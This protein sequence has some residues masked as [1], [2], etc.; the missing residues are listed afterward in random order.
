MGTTSLGTGLRLKSLGILFIC[1]L[2]AGIWLTYGVF[3]Q[4]FTDFDE[5][6]LDAPAIGL[7]MPERADVK[8]RGVIVGQVL[9][10]SATDEGATV[11]LGIYPSQL[12]TIPSNVTGAIVPKTLFGEKYVSLVVPHDEPATTSLQPGSTIPRTH[13]PVEVQKVLADLYPLLRTVQ[14]ADLNLTLNAISTALEGRGEALGGD[15]VTVDRYLKRINPQIPQLV[16]Y[17][18]LTTKVSNTYA[19]VLPSI[20]QI[21]DNTITTTGTL[22]DRHQQ[23]QALFTDVSSLSDIAR[24]FLRANGDNIIRLGQVSRPQAQMLARYAP[25]YPCLLGGLVNAGKREAQAF[26]GFTLHIV[27]ETLPN[28]PRGYTAADRPVYADDRGPNCLH[29]PSPPWTQSNPVRHQPDFRDGIDSPTGKGTDRVAPSW[30]RSF[31]R[32]SGYAG[33]AAE[34]GLLKSLLGPSLGMSPADVP[35]L[36]VLLVGPMA[37][38]AEVSLR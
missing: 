28:Q 21:L 23:L 11:R 22:E 14:P 38:G 20:A 1:L 36:G 6:T 3:T 26:R 16:Q 19:D 15:L 31:T 35:D 34:A 7:Q 2:L 32:G 17:L 13:V 24:D 18:R 9:G 8:I 30:G 4:R 27:L 12:H 25:E 33:G 29:L 10:F 37:R 5:V